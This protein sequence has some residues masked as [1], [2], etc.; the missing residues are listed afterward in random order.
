[1]RYALF[2]VQL[3]LIERDPLHQTRLRRV[4]SGCRTHQVFAARLARRQGWAT[5][6]AFIRK[7]TRRSHL[8][9]GL[10]LLDLAQ[11]LLIT[12]HTA[13]LGYVGDQMRQPFIVRLGDLQ[14]VPDPLLIVLLTPARFRIMRTLDARFPI[15]RPRLPKD[16][17]AIS[18]FVLLPPDRAQ[19]L[20]FWQLTQPPRRGRRSQPFQQPLPILPRLGLQHRP[21][22]LVQPLRHAPLPIPL[23]PRWR[24]RRTCPFR[25]RRQ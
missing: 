4:S 9:F 25:F 3:E 20:D 10:P 13:R 15:I 12:L 23:F 5:H 21:L 19:D 18:Y 8:T 11:S 6:I 1:M 17:R 22:A 7:A 14:F 2:Q 24:H 16:Y